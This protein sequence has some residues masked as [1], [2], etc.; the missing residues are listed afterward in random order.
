ME[1]TEIVQLQ[2][3][4][5]SI[6]GQTEDLKILITFQNAW[7]NAFNHVTWGKPRTPQGIGC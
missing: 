3:Y 4:L 2:S 7:P 5:N 1:L 6:L